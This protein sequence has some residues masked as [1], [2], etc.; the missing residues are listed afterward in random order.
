MF[1]HNSSKMTRWNFGASG[2]V[3]DDDADAAL[4]QALV[5]NA[6][7]HC[8]AGS[9]QS[10][11]G[12]ASG[13]QRVG[14]GVGDVQKGEGGRAFNRVGDAVHCVGGEQRAFRAAALQVARGLGEALSDSVP[15]SGFHHRREVGEV[16]GCHQDAGGM[17]SAAPPRDF[18]VEPPVILGGRHPRHSAD[19]AD[20]FHSEKLSRYNSPAF[21]PLNFAARAAARRGG[22]SDRSAANNF[23]PSASARR[24]GSSTAK[25]NSPRAG[26]SP[27]AARAD[28]SFSVPTAICSRAFVNSR[29]TAARVSPPSDS[30]KRDNASAKRGGDS[31]NTAQPGIPHNS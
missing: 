1:L 2:F 10:D 8:V 17:Q 15:L 24:P 13:L 5:I 31:N 25:Q 29:P 20:C 16:H 26:M 11:G 12:D 3:R 7:A 18:R 28:N 9:E 19:D 22:I 21:A 14:E 23:R 4:F 6:G 27:F 30:D